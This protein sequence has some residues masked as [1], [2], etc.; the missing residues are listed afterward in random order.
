MQFMFWNDTCKIEHN[1]H[2]AYR[3]FLHDM[4]FIR[5]ILLWTYVSFLLDKYAERSWYI[6]IL[7]LGIYSKTT[8]SWSFLQ[9]IEHKPLH[10]AMDSTK[11]C[12]SKLGPKGLHQGCSGLLQ[13]AW[14]GQ[15]PCT[16]SSFGESC[17][18]WNRQ[19]N[20][21]RAFEFNHIEQT[22]MDSTAVLM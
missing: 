7:L 1:M 16:A 9:H 19:H 8:S 15:E 21:M 18:Q 3:A 5:F 22:E 4:D 14:L 2:F 12:C 6:M 10:R 20:Q 17:S 11:R 13:K